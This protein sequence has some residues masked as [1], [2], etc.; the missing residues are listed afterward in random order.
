MT[1]FNSY[2]HKCTLVTSCF[3]SLKHQINEMIP[4]RYNKHLNTQPIL[5]SFQYI[6][7]IYDRKRD[8]I[9][10]YLKF[11]DSCHHVNV[12]QQTSQR[13][14]N[15]CQEIIEKVLKCLRMRRFT[16]YRPLECF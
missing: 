16:H 12:K 14:N 4:K 7:N 10:V 2:E 11:T 13:I 9:L 1:N 8:Y 15:K 5:D 6:I 3:K